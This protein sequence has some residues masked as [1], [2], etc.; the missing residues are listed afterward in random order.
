[1]TKRLV[2]EHALYL[3][4]AGHATD[5]LLLLA[6]SSAGGYPLM[7]GLLPVKCQIHIEESFTPNLR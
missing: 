7:L 2:A 4:L 3:E 6:D 1:M 5:R